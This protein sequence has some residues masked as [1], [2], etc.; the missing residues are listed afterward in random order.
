VKYEK[1]D[2]QNSRKYLLS[3]YWFKTPA[4]PKSHLQ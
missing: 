4:N 2:G 3:E 1:Y